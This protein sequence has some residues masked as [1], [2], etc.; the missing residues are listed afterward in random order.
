MT[1]HM[2]Q[3]GLDPGVVLD[4]QW[5]AAAAELV[6]ARTLHGAPR[7]EFDPEGD[8]M[9]YDPN[10]VVDVKSVD[11]GFR[12]I[13]GGKK[14]PRSLAVVVTWTSADVPAIHGVI[15]RELWHWGLPPV[16][17]RTPIACWFVHAHEVDT[18]YWTALKVDEEEAVAPD[19]AVDYASPTT[20]LTFGIDTASPMLAEDLRRRRW[21]TASRRRLA[22]VK[23]AKG[24]GWAFPNDT[25]RGL[26]NGGG[27]RPPVVHDDDDDTIPPSRPR[28]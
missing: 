28:P 9:L 14:R 21:R 24:L 6:V 23:S 16:P 20:R 4:R 2:E 17:G 8:V 27:G 18:R 19:E 5:R 26:G 10:I 25:P 22:R 11:E 3:S 7:T 1:T 13:N 15:Y 12:F